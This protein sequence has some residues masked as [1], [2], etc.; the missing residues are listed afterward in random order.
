MT[1]PATLVSGAGTS[2]W[3]AALVGG[4]LARHTGVQV[5]ARCF[6]VAQVIAATRR[7]HP[8]VVLVGHD[9]DGLDRDAVVDLSAHCGTVVGA[10]PPA[11]PLAVRRLI[12]L[13]CRR[14]VPHDLDP[15]DLARLVLELAGYVLDVPDPAGGAERGRLVAVWGPTG[16]PGRTTVA[17]GLA[18][19]SVAAGVDT[20]LLDADPYGASLAQ[21]LGLAEHP[22]L[23]SALRH[24]A[25]G[26]FDGAALREH[27]LPAAGGLWLLAGLA[28]PDAWTEVREGSLRAVLDAARDAFPLVVVDAGFCLE[29]DEELTYAGTPLRRNLTTRAVVAAAS[30]VVGVCRADPVGLRRYV[31]AWPDVVALSAGPV[32]TV[33]NRSPGSVAGRRKMEMSLALER[34]TGAPPIT[35]VPDD[36]AVVEC[37]WEGRSPLSAR[38]RS[39]A[40]RAMA[41]LVRD[42]VGEWPEAS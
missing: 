32:R 41:S 9:L 1:A 39:P 21:T 4:L 11:D 12:D 6:E 31:D 2:P 37:L 33:V 14:A 30:S 5:V 26:A 28:R 13:G 42:V 22:S 24:A 19:A 7:V 18:S 38:P 3:E 8:D 27:C 40:A 36:P 16:A 34:R 15:L 29:E 25:D 23:L 17:L 35:V 10:Y 20:L